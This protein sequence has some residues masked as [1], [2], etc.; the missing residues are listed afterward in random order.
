MCFFYLNTIRNYGYKV[1]QSTSL[2]L[3]FSLSSV[4][5]QAKI[6]IVYTSNQP[7]I[8]L[9][10]QVAH[11]PELGTL[12]KR[13]RS[14]RNSNVLFLHG[15]DSFSP[16]AI[17]LFDHASNIIA[18]ANLMDV[19]LYAVGKRELTYDVDTLSL[20][21]LE[22][23]FPIVS[24]NVLDKRS[25][26]TVEGVFSHYEFDID[27]L[28]VS[29]ASIV[30]PRT[31]ITH[32]PEQAEIEDTDEVLKKVVVQQKNADIKVLMTDLKMADIVEISKKYSFDLILSAIDGKDEIVQ[33]G[34]TIIINGGGQDGDAVVIEYDK[35]SETK[36][37]AKVIDLS[38]YLPDP[39]IISLTSQY[40]VR[41]G[42][43][44]N[45]KI[46]VSKELF[47]TQK[48]L[49]RTQ[50]TALANVFVD[51]LKEYSKADIAVINSGAIRNSEVYP[52]GYFFTREDIQQEFP[53]GGY[54]VEVAM[55]KSEL[56]SMMENAVSRIEYAD[57]RFMNVAGMSVL[58]NSKDRVG[59][60]IKSITVSGK[61]LE[62]NKIYT[63]AMQDF[64][65]KGGDEYTMLKDKTPLN[66]LF[67]KRRIWHI[68]TDY[69][70]KLK[71]IEAPLLNRLIDQASK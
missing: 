64:F 14:K 45:E 67:S 20:R 11:F 55:T 30:S 51:A 38:K 1:L 4:Y 6:T 8:L 2:F 52:P 31:L 3:L 7:D 58:Y 24:S 39:D 47:T 68:V 48:Q 59:E 35:F 65:L 44:F 21:S 34:S 54:Y 32:A 49:I 46:A 60:R 37:S 61:E 66:N 69:M 40:R 33:H 13:L 25:G 56:Y 19:S 27:E 41:L 57:G 5:A 29:V 43:L 26:T 15:G 62:S 70:I 18:L 16:S 28:T 17:S 9:K 42:K 10:K 71:E 53:F 12:L 50:E 22:A 23:Q 63:M 36:L